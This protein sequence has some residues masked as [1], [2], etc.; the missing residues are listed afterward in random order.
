MKNFTFEDS[1][2]RIAD[3]ADPITAQVG[4]WTWTL[5]LQGPEYSTG[6]VVTC[7]RTGTVDPGPQIKDRHSLQRQVYNFV[8]GGLTYLKP[9]AVTLFQDL[10]YNEAIP[11]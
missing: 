8:L 7:T 10:Q 9:G 3:E 4:A 2:F 5:T 11:H 1:V 6:R